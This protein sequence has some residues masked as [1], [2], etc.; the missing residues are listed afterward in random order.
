MKGSARSSFKDAKARKA[1]GAPTAV[2]ARVLEDLHQSRNP[3]RPIHLGQAGRRAHADESVLA[4]IG[5]QRLQDRNGLGRL[6]AAQSRRRRASQWKIA[7]LLDD[8]LQQRQRLLDLQL[9]EEL[10]GSAPLVARGSGLED[11][12]EHLRPGWAH[13]PQLVGQLLH[14]LPVRQPSQRVRL[15]DI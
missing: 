8:V 11:L 13:L 15:V 5:Q 1:S 12:Q 4:R 10:S 9:P 3:L 2:H 6:K 14:A 7:V